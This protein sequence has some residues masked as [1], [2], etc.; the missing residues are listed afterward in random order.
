MIAARK[1]MTIHRAANPP[2]PLRHTIAPVY[3]ASGLAA[4]I[5]LGVSIAGLISPASIYPTP[6]LRRDLVS[7]DL[8][9]LVAGL[10]VLLLSIWLASR[11]WLVGLLA[12]PGALFFALYIH[13]IHLFALPYSAAY[14]LHLTLVALGSYTVIALVAS[15]DSWSVRDRLA[16][17]VPEQLA[18]ILL[19]GQGLLNFIW[20]AAA[21][22]LPLIGGTSASAAEIANHITDILVTPA[23]MIGGILLWRH[24]ALGYVVGL[25]LLLQGG[26]FFVALAVMALWQSYANAASLDSLNLLG[27]LI[28]GLVCFVPLVLYLRGAMATHRSAPQE[29]RPQQALH[30]D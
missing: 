24:R 15:I 18:G 26:L 27:I 28:A 21:L 9:D 4:I 16:G 3:I 20:V 12:W 19:A 5:A 10:P 6:D 23:W 30:D 11:G 25:G 17:A 22:V 13:L 1:T 7:L 2:L 29:T 8:V 14:L